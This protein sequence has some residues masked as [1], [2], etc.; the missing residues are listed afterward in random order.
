VQA[1]R[2]AIPAWRVLAC[3]GTDSVSSPPRG[4]EITTPS[5]T[6]SLEGRLDSWKEI[7]AYL[8]R[9]VRTVQRWERE[10]GLPVHRLAHDRR[11]TIY[12]RRE[13]L[14]EW[15][16]SRRVTLATQASDDEIRAPGAA[17]AAPRFE[18]VTRTST[19]T[20]WPALSSDARLIAYVSD[21]GDDRTVP[22]IWVQQ[23]DGAALQLTDGD[24]EYSDL[25]FSP[26]DTH[27]LFTRRD[28]STPNI[29]EIPTLGGEMRLVQHAAT[30]GRFSPNG[31][32]LA[33]IPRDG[34]GIRIAARGGAGFRTIAP[35]LV[36]VV[37][38]TW[39]PDSAAVLVEARS[40][41]AVEL[42]WWIVPIDGTA[43]MTTRLIQRLREARMFVLPMAP[44]WSDDALVFS[45]AMMQGICLYRQR[46][47][48]A[49]LE[50]ID[51]PEQLTLGGESALLPTA[52][53]GRIAFI[54][55]Q[56][57]SNFWSVSLDRESGIASGPLKRVTR[58]AGI[59][60]YLSLSRD[61]RTLAY[62]SVRRGTFDVF[63]RDLET[64]TERVLVAGPPG[65]KS[66]PAIS[67]DGREVAFGQQKGG[68]RTA[69][70]IFIARLS[71]GTWR[72]LGDD[73]GGRPRQ[74]IDERWIV[75]ERY[76]RLHS[77]ALI[78]AETAEQRELLQSDE[79]SLKN[80]RVSP[81]GRWIAFDG[82]RPGGSVNVYVAAFRSEHIPESE[83]I[84]V[85]RAASHP[86]W[87]ADGRML[88]YMSVGTSTAFRSLI[89]ARRF[90]RDSAGPEGESV[91]VYATAELVMPAY[92]P[93]T[94]PIATADQ[95]ICALG[96]YRGDIWLMDL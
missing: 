63:L 54:S 49:T 41:P 92:L 58:G 65:P 40:D 80:P 52:G 87:S 15:W 71:E 88:Y 24:R 32:W 14:S 81:D 66:Y 86:F 26:N 84:C 18:R 22:Q 27:I 48:P 64:G 12:A 20:E 29:Y 51:A 69:R 4:N 72:T 50:P 61:L 79:L 75:M 67:P 16:E 34:K 11:G 45:G 56:Q 9:G 10:E 2:R 8:G 5:S 28:D 62:F 44:A 42:E 35:D 96:D 55:R 53:G 89:R 82:E 83:W 73:C 39:R 38:L 43:P 37:S 57:D 19:R 95:I 23:V 33:G 91:I 90:S 93:G 47:V 7:A 70:P 59:V 21:G 13:E 78:D 30:T 77:I 46:I 76:S 60:G 1:T 74:W 68:E 36:E 94:A 3:I 6:P 25:S 31:Q 17:P 85:E